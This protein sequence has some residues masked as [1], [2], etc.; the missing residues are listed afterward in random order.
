MMEMQPSNRTPTLIKSK[1]VNELSAQVQSL[2]GKHGFWELSEVWLTATAV[3]IPLV[4]YPFEL[5]PLLFAALSSI[6][7]ALVFAA[8]WMANRRGNEVS[9]AKSALMREKDEQFAHDL[10]DKDLQI[11]EQ[12]EHVLTFAKELA[13]ARTK[14]AEAELKLEEVRKKQQSRTVGDEFDE[15]L[16]GKPIGNIVILYQAGNPE[17]LMFAFDL[18]E[19]LSEL[20]WQ[21]PRLP[22]VVPSDI[23]EQVGGSTDVLLFSPTFRLS[24]EIKA[25][26]E[27][28][29]Q[30][31]HPP[32]SHGLGDM[33]YKSLFGHSTPV[34]LVN[35]K[36]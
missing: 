23:N 30:S 31:G 25:L 33:R 6:A 8:M 14:Q 4:L 10:R 20:G 28:L 16:K 36:P 13:E 35:H 29:V 26:Q 24:E 12:R 1:R 22:R 3:I 21:S 9:A 18:Y 34:L 5:A 27:A 2:E 11:G 19:H 7:P 15:V 32:I 17:T